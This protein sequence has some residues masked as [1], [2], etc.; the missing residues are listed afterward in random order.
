MYEGIIMYF[1]LGLLWL[2]VN[3]LIYVF[4]PKDLPKQGMSNALRFRLF[5]FW[6]VTFISFVLGIIQA[7]RDYDEY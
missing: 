5:L 3:E 1:K 6:P 2:V 4:Q 7:F